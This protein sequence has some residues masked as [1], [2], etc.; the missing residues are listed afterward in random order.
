MS[1]EIAVFPGRVMVRRMPDTRLDA[2][3]AS[4]AVRIHHRRRAAAG[5][6]A[7]WAAASEVRLRDTRTLGRLVRWRIPGLDPALTYHDLFR[8][9]PFTVLEEDD[10][11]MVSG[12]AGRIWTLARDYPR[13]D[14]P[15]AFADWSQ[16]GT[17]RVLIAH[18]VEPGAEGS[19]LVSEAR[20]EPVDRVAALRLRALWSV[21]GPFQRLVGVEPLS[22]AA[23]RAAQG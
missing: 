3:I 6:D 15:E 8:G 12:M 1:N 9:Y 11:R 17:V 19:E 5:P 14:G 2:W 10:R 16:P 21:M 18:W 7:L 23:R 4:P 22:L 20:V 13:L